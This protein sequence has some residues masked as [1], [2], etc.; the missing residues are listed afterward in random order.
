MA[1]AIQKLR[2]MKTLGMVLGYE[3]EFATSRAIR[4]HNVAGG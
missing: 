3:Q 4:F 1:D 2:G